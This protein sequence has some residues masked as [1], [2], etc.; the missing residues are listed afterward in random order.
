[1]LFIGLDYHQGKDR[2]YLINLKE[3]QAIIREKARPRNPDK[4]VK[5][6]IYLLKYFVGYD[7]YY[8]EVFDS[9]EA[10]DKR[11]ENVVKILRANDLMIQEK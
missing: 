10:R 1:M 3:V 6:G 8:E 11:Y 7:S 9:A 2:T 5:T 4:S